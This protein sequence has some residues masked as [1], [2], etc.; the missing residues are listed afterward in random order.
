MRERTVKGSRALALFVATLCAA[1]QR[2]TPAPSPTSLNGPSS[3][4]VPELPR[5]A[6]LVAMPR[7]AEW[8]DIGREATDLLQQYLRINTTNP[9]GDEIVAARWMQAVLAR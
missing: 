7:G 3:A 5:R 2:A 9:P 6:A 4:P 8:T 1:C